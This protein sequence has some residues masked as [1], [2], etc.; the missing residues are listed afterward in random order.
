MSL[1][2]KIREL[3]LRAGLT[4]AEAARRGGWAQASSYHRYEDQSRFTRKWLPM[5]VAERLSNAF[6]GLGNPQITTG[7]ILALTQPAVARST[8]VVGP[9]RV[10]EVIA[11]VEAGVWREAVELP[12]EEREYFPMPNLPG[13]EGVEVFGLRVR[14]ASMNLIYPEGSIAFFVR[15]EDLPPADGHTVVVV[16]KRGDLYETTLKELGRDKKNKVVLFPRSN[17]P[18]YQMPI[19]PGNQGA[20]S[21]EIIGVAIG[22]FELMSAPA[23]SRS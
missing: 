20:E 2:A 3:R 16:K 8:R 21:V 7:E 11:V 15:P 14:G 22:K 9:S 18:R 23:R 19:Y 6:V 13:Y 12:H 10:V 4:V 1:T 5:D 17:D